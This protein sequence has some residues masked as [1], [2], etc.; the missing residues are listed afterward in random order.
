MGHRSEKE[1]IAE[2]APRGGCINARA[3]GRACSKTVYPE[4]A[5]CRPSP[6]GLREEGAEV[7]G[8]NGYTVQEDDI[9]ATG[10]A[11]LTELHKECPTCHVFRPVELWECPHCPDPTNMPADLRCPECYPVAPPVMHAHTYPPGPTTQFTLPDRGLM[12]PGKQAAAENFG[13]PEGQGPGKQ[14]DNAVL[15]DRDNFELSIGGIKYDA[16]KLPYDLMPWDA[17]DEVVKVLRFGAKKYA[18]RNWEQGVPFRWGRM[19][20]AAFRHL[21]AWSMGEDDDAET[22]LSHLA[23]CLCMLLFLL[24][25]V[26][27]KRGHDDRMR[28]D[29]LP[30]GEYKELTPDQMDRILRQKEMRIDQTGLT[31]KFPDTIVCNPIRPEHSKEEPEPYI[32]RL[33]F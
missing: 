22:G 4:C 33:P 11:L 25:H 30:P 9:L 14:T 19:S 5:V 21:K 15:A 7:L 6:K 13:L 10:E 29:Q 12:G 20:A 16:G 24:A 1:L 32:E 17:V 18:S 2:V 26:L 3:D 31:E 28:V 23:H 27:R 8:R